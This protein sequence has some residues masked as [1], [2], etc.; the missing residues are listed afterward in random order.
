MENKELKNR[1]KTIAFLVSG[2]QDDFTIKMCHGVMGEAAHDDM[3]LVVVPVKYINR[4]FTDLPDKYEYQYETNARQLIPENV[5]ALIVA[6]DCIGCLTTREVQMRFMD[7]LPKV[8]TVMIAARVDGYPGVNF[9][10]RTGVRDG[11]T[12]L[13]EEMGVTK[14]GMLGG[15]DDYYDILERK[16]AFEEIVEKYA[17]PF[18][19]SMFVRTNLS[20]VCHNEVELLLDMNPDLEAIFCVNDDVAMTLYE[21]MRSRGLE[22]GVDIK[23]MG[24]DNNRNAAMSN[25]ALCTVDAD[26]VELGRHAF[27]MVQR[28][29]RGEEVGSETTPTRFILRDSFGMVE[30]SDDSRSTK[31]RLLD[32]KSVDD[33]F[34]KVFYRYRDEEAKDNSRLRERYHQLMKDVIS[35]VRM[36]IHD[37]WILQNI[38]D[39]VEE[40]FIK[41]GALEYTDNNELVP[42]IERLIAEIV[43]HYPSMEMKC[44]VIESMS[45]VFKRMLKAQSNRIV[46]FESGMDAMLYSTKTLVKDSLNFTY[47]ND[48]SY[49]NIVASLPQLGINNGCVY[50]YEKPVVHLDKENF[51]VQ[52]TVRLKAAMLKGKVL[53]IPYSQ[54]KLSLGNIFSHP[55][56]SKH[57]WLMVMMPLYFGD[58][59][60][61]N[62]LV[63]LTE[64]MFRNG[65]FLTN[66]FATT[67][68]MIEILRQ[69]N[70]IQKQL[71]ENLA[72][73]AEN[74]IAL[75]KLSRNDV[76]TGILNR[77]GFYDKAREVIEGE[78]PREQDVILSYVDMNNLKVINDRFG[79][80]DGD[81]SLRTISDVLTE[82]VGECGTVGRI[83]G[84]EYAFI[85]V[86]PLD[87]DALR[88]KVAERLAA[89]NRESS[90]PYN[91]TVSCGFYR[92]KP[93]E[94]ISLDD[95]MAT[96]DLDLYEAKRFKDNRVVK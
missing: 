58:T 87:E 33:Q 7:S 12:Y 22:P 38:M 78:T 74:N 4:D 29:L 24:F 52:K 80:D 72:I 15:S 19:E 84:D 32:P 53:D 90:L 21:V 18:R 77:R 35:Y 88:K 81:L 83:G 3:N 30:S 71:E 23:V 56:L 59:V 91:I 96:A 49:E 2:L 20:T 40:F 39:S 36:G 85:Y 27:H 64:I 14:I 62:I 26:A 60:Y 47:G 31:E 11:L 61:G 68:R 89:F 63:D 76:L 16:K 57:R 45:A 48:K 95:A 73:M 43:G 28:I 25:P 70:E 5:D 8:P 75:D 86:G 10:N 41:D 54:Q 55:R 82:V 79:H 65:E 69:N 34:D 42:Y 13:V 66:Q 1:R 50:I 17:L 93:E 51:P 67:A 92:V 37:S 46:K 94:K 9:D 44:I 6:L